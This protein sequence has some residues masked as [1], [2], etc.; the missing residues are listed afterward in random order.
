MTIDNNSSGKTRALTSADINKITQEIYE[1]EGAQAADIAYHVHAQTNLA[2]PAKQNLP[3]LR[4]GLCP[5]ISK[6]ATASP[7]PQ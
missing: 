7:M 2:L 5:L 6:S 1:T 4:T 3:T